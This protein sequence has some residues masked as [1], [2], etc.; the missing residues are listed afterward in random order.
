MKWDTYARIS[1][2]PND[3][4]RGVR[5]Q[6]Q[7]TRAHVDSLG[8]NVAKAHIEN[9][10][11]AYR[12]KRVTVTDASGN[13]Y[14]GFRVIRPVWHEALQRLRTDQADGLVVYDLDRLA[15]DPRDLED[16]IE[17]VEHYGKAIVSATASEINLSTETGRMAARLMVVMANKSSA[18][19]ARRVRR[20]ALANAQDGKPV[21]KR[22]FGWTD[23]HL[24]LDPAEAALVREAVAKLL[25]GTT[26][27]TAI[28]REWNEAGV[29]TARGNDWRNVTV[30]Q[31][32][33]HPRLA[34]YRVTH[35]DRR[36]EL[37]RDADGAPV[38]G[39]WPPLLDVDTWERLQGVLTSR[40]TRGR[41]PKKSKRFY[42]LAGI[43]RCGICNSPMYGNYSKGRGRHFYKCLEYGR[44][45]G[46]TG[47]IRHTQ[48]IQGPTTD[49][50]VTATVLAWLAQQQDAVVE[51]RPATWDGEDDLQRARDKIAELMAAFNSDELP[52]SVV[53]PQV[54]EWEARA[55]DLDNQ[56]KAWRATSAP[57]PAIKGALEE[58][59]ERVEAGDVTWQRAV[60]ASVLDAV[61]IKQRTIVG[62]N[63]YEYDR[64]A[65]LWR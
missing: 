59:P 56:R 57:A 20:A 4:Q 62:T 39:Q 19:T 1:E 9:D 40:D 41:V 61:V 65:Y 47:Y 58:W 15:R 32:L 16:A 52:G 36:N 35:S 5:R 18:D 12:K 34:G 21:G 27:A 63:E 22:A 38:I 49:R 54:R 37:V 2:D 64:L 29:R 25:D 11:S 8:G 60:I 7:D 48:S 30:R 33:R 44:H 6:N 13:Q 55:T 46:V 45:G 24:S 23:D 51:Q 53:F 50:A 26:T 3:E 14:D 17:V 42:L 10:S 28:A 43:I 31:Y